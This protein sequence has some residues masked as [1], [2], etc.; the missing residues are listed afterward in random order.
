MTNAN[1][2]A[3]KPVA[4]FDPLLD[5]TFTRMVDVPRALVWRAWTEP[6]LLKPWFCPKPWVTIDCEIDLRPGGIF[7]TV[8]QSPQGQTFPG[9][10]CY[11]EV[12]ANTK[13]VWTSALLP[14]FRPRAAT[15]PDAQANGEFL[16]TATVELADQDGGTRYTATVVHADEEGCKKHAAMGF[17]GGWGTALDQLVAHIKAGQVA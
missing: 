16:F 11:L 17:E 2:N 5:L 13:L 12:I 6:E 1:A 9:T 3:T 15:S 10:G 14:G 4:P 8:M 7:K